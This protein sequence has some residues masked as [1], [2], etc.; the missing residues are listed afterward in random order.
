METEVSLPCSERPPPVCI[1]SHLNT[2]HNLMSHIFNIHFSI[3][4]SP[5][6]GCPKWSPPLQVFDQNVVFFIYHACY[7]PRPSHPHLFKYSDRIT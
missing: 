1:M 4:F 6:L 5:T 7:S 2:V 3:T